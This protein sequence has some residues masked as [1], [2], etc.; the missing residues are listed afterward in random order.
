MCLQRRAPLN[1]HRTHARETKNAP[2][3]EVPTT[4][5]RERMET[6]A[7]HDLRANHVCALL[8]WVIVTAC[9]LD[10][11]GGGL[12]GCEVKGTDDPGSVCLEIR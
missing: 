6:V 8:L 4:L 2:L 7:G 9:S 10:V 11:S 12:V 3:D 1:I 5:V